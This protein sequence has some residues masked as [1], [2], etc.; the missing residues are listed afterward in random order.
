[1]GYWIHTTDRIQKFV[2]EDYR[3]M[4]TRHRLEPDVSK[5]IRDLLRKTFYIAVTILVGILAS[6][7]DK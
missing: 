7:L 1:M 5:L 2:H 6:I 4:T 3:R